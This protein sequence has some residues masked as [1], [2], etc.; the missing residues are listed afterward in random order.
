MLVSDTDTD[1]HLFRGVGAT[2]I[3]VCE[4]NVSSICSGQSI[5]C[6]CLPVF[7]FVVVVIQLA[8]VILLPIPIR[9]KAMVPPFI[10]LRFDLSFS[11]SLKIF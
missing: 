1:T 7:T 6:A 10:V 9:D 3:I 5:I 8:R 11:L 4:D 2:K